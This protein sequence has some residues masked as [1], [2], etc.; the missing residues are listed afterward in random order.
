[1]FTSLLRSRMTNRL[2]R[3]SVRSRPSVEA[4][5]DRLVLNHTPLAP[6]F[7]VNTNSVAGFV[8]PPAVV[9]ASDATGD[10]VVAWTTQLPT[11]GKSSLR[12]A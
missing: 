3:P 6:E 4:L 2:P 9:T 1:M 5:E 8:A 12:N 10:F 11:Q 7:I